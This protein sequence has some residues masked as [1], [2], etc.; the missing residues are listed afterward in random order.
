MNPR[1]AWVSFMGERRA[2]YERLATHRVDTA[3]RSA[4]HVAQ[5]IA[6]LLAGAS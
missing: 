6:A 3:G 2:T 1:A 4:D 5:D